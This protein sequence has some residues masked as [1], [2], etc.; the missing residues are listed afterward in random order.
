VSTEGIALLIA[1]IAAYSATGLLIRHLDG[2]HL[3]L[4]FSRQAV[5]IQAWEIE[6]L[7]ERLRNRPVRVQRETVFLASPC[8]QPEIDLPES[9]GHFPSSWIVPGGIT[10]EI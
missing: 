1:A 6:Q 2:L 4:G 3:R 7:H 8:R 10:T 9:L 5:E